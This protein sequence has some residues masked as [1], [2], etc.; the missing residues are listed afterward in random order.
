MEVTP[1][2]SSLVVYNDGKNVRF[3]CRCF[4]NMSYILSHQKGITNIVFFLIK[5]NSLILLGSSKQLPLS[6]DPSWCRYYW[7]HYLSF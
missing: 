2:P 4:L 6:Y 5:S 7:L 1:S 3:T